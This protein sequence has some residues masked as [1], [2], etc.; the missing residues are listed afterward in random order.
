LR[1]YCPSNQI[2]RSEMA[3]FL[4]RGIRGADYTPP[5]ASG[6]VFTDVPASHW[7]AAWIEQLRLDGITG[8]CWANPPA[9]CPESP[10]TRAQMAVFLLR[11]RH[12]F[13]YTPPAATGTIFTDVP[14]T[15]WAAAWIE[16]LYQEGITAGCT[17]PPALP[18][19]CPESP[20]LRREM[21]VFLVRTFNLP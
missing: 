9:Y 17:V 15:H 14:I 7:A 18:S 2:K 10:V 19:Y 13:D 5:P 8:G 6:A 21:A 1:D 16:Q 4:E 20:N 3:V 12:G 11:A